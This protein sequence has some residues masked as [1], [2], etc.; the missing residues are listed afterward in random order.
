MGAKVRL[1]I[2]SPLEGAG[3]E[4]SVPDGYLDV[5]E[6]RNGETVFFLPKGTDPRSLSRNGKPEGSAH[7]FRRGLLP[8]PALS[9]CERVGLLL[10]FAPAAR[11]DH[12]GWISAPISPLPQPAHV[13]RSA[14]PA[15][16]PGRGSSTPICRSMRQFYRGRIRSRRASPATEA[17]PIL[18]RNL[19]PQKRC[20]EPPRRARNS[21]SHQPHKIGNSSLT[22]PSPFERSWCSRVV[23]T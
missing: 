4:P 8:S 6:R 11:D 23:L 5:R 1:A 9:N 15:R 12:R 20:G 13:R 21:C 7:R 19:A 18:Y 3:F 22:T 2:D 16:R 10:L 14:R 17:G